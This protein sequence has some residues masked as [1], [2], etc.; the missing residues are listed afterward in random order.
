MAKRTPLQVTRLLDL[1]NQSIWQRTQGSLY[2]SVYTQILTKI[3]ASGALVKCPRVLF[4][5][6]SIISIRIHG[7]GG[8][9]IRNAENSR[10]MRKIRE[11]F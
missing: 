5:I 11:K 3:E 7:K 4:I 8:Q 1:K 6:S 9:V 10:E 2:M